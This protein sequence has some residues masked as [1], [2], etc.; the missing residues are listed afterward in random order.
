MQP[1]IASAAILPLTDLAEFHWQEHSVLKFDLHKAF[2]NIKLE[3]AS[4]TIL[5]DAAAD[6]EEEIL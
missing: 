1:Q 5:R 2:D 3:V 4:P 6:R